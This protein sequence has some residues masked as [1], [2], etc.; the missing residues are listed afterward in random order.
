MALYGAYVTGGSSDT[1]IVVP[2]KSFFAQTELEEE[3]D[4]LRTQWACNCQ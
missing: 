3:E 2:A 1:L 4:I